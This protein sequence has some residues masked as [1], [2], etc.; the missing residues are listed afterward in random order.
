MNEEVRDLFSRPTASIPDTGR[1]CFGLSRNGS[2][3]AA[4]AGNLGDII[5]VG[6]LRKVVTSSLR[7]KLGLEVLS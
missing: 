5:E 6:K 4:N 3:A 7:K 2:Y 1:I